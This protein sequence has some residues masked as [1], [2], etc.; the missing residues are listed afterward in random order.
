VFLE[1]A[2]PTDPT[3]LNRFLNY[4]R[5]TGLPKHRVRW[6][7]NYDLPVGRGKT[8]AR[9]APNWLNEII[10]G[11]KFSGTG[12]FVSTWF[13]MPVNQWGDT[14]NFEVYRKKYPILD[15][16]AT[17]T[18]ASTPQDERCFP[19]YLYFNGYISERYINSRNANGMRDGVYGLPADYHPAE[20]PVNP[21]PKGGKSGAAGSTDWDT[22]NVYIYLKNGA[23]QQVAKDT[24]L[25]PWRNQYVRGPFNWSMDGSLL[26]FFRITERTRLRM[27]FDMFNLLNNQGLNTPG[28]DG[29]VTLQNSYGGFGMKPRQ[30][31]VAAR[32][33]W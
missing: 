29:I 19:G 4:Q 27:N 21:W 32:L 15:C 33:E 20:K 14:S 2:V 3:T 28:S 16:R 1:G 23:R 11:W 30:V 7:W 10:G 5:D 9:N 8:L 18:T 24:N 6:N 25:H 31:Q 13:A 26:K 12:T 17:P 22:N